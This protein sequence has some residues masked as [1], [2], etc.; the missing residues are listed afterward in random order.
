MFASGP[1]GSSTSII[2]FGPRS[3]NDFSSP[4]LIMVNRKRSG[5][6]SG[7]SAQPVLTSRKVVFRAVPLGGST[8]K[9]PLAG[10]A[11]IG[12]VICA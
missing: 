12:T 1:C 4:F 2:S 6:S 11:L 5:M 10:A 7:S 3:A 9:M 8:V